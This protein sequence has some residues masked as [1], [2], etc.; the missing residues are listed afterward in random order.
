MKRLSIFFVFVFITGCFLI[1]THETKSPSI[2]T[3]HL[4]PP[5][6]SEPLKSKKNLDATVAIFPFDF[7]LKFSEE[8]M[9]IYFDYSYLPKEF[10]QNLAV[11]LESY[12]FNKVIEME[13]PKKDITPKSIAEK[14]SNKKADVGIYG[15]VS[16]IKIGKNSDGWFGKLKLKFLLVAH[17]GVIIKDEEKDFLIQKL[18]FPDNVTFDY[19]SAMAASALFNDVYNSILKDLSSSTSQIEQNR[20]IKAIVRGKGIITIR[21]GDQA[22]GK[23]RLL[24]SMRIRI[25]V[26]DLEKVFWETKKNIDEKIKDYVAEINRKNDYKLTIHIRDQVDT[27]YPFKV[28][29]VTYDS[30]NDTYNLIYISTK[31]FY[32]TPGKSLVIATFSMPKVSEEITKGLY[33][34]INPEK[35]ANIGFNL[36]CDTKNNFLDMGFVR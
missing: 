15:K 16:E 24:I 4:L 18:N 11:M 10:G 30:N 3:I 33:L 27:I 35:G 9:P 19:Q 13:L 23:S 31:E 29:K 14:V 20:S 7:D 12:F 2:I 25:L 1:F 21:R 8:K 36:L 32:V 34:D 26:N 5:K 22:R 6:V 17:N 28:G